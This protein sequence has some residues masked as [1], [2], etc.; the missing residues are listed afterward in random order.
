VSDP[1]S[2]VCTRALQIAKCT[3]GMLPQAGQILNEVLTELAQTYDLQTNITTTTITLTG[4]TPNNGVGPYNLPTD[5]LR[6]CSRDL[7][8]YVSGVPRRLIQITLAQFDIL[9]NTLG[10]SSYPGNYATDI[11]QQAVLANGNPVLYVYPPPLL[12]IP[13]Q[14]RYF[15][16]PLDIVTPETSSSIPWFPNSTYLIRRVAGELMAI[17]GDP[18]ADTYLGDGPQGCIGILRRWLNL[19]GDREDTASTIQL[20]AR[21]FGAGGAAYEPSKITG[22]V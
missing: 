20:D 11:S 12:V 4:N 19:Q 1:A 21:Y 13:L 18:R 14:I 7:T 8:Y 10:V 3:S 9:I 2:V 16:L 17:T 6:A 22:G 5:Y 15:N